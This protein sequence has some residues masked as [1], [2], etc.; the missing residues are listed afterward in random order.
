MVKAQD[1]GRITT[2][3]AT[4]VQLSLFTDLKHSLY[5]AMLLR[6]HVDIPENMSISVLIAALV[7][8]VTHL[9]DTV[10]ELTTEVGNLKNVIST[11]VR[12]Y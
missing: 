3:A 4:P 6:R 2:D 12:R 7:E 9:E 10:A 8:R 5:N 1:D 11:R